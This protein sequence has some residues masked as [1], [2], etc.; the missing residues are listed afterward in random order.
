MIRSRLYSNTKPSEG[1][2]RIRRNQNLFPCLILVCIFDPHSLPSNRAIANTLPLIHRSSLYGDTAKKAD[3]DD[4]RTFNPTSQY[5]HWIQTTARP[6]PR[7]LSMIGETFSHYKIVEKLGEGGMGVVYKAEDLRLGRVVALKFLSHQLGDD[8]TA[9]R[10]LLQ[11][12]KAASAINHQNVCI[13]YDIGE[14]QGKEFISMEYVEGE[15]LRRKF[16]ATPLSMNEA[17][18]YAVQI[19]EGLAAAHDKGII[20]RDVKPDNIMVGPHGVIK[21]MDFGLAKLRDAYLRTRATGTVGTLAYMAPEQIQGG[22]VDARA[23]IFGFGVVLYEMLTQRL[24]FRGAHEAAMMYSIL[25]EEPE[26]LQKHLP[27]A[28]PELIHLLQK[29]LEKEVADR[30]QSIHEMVVDIRRLQKRS[31]SSI[32]TPSGRSTAHDSG[33][34]RLAAIMFTDM[35]GYSA[36]T[37]KNE[38]LALEL[39]STHRRIVRSVLPIYGGKE[40][41][42]IGDGF[43]IE[44]TS[45]LEA[46]RCACT[47]QKSMKEYNDTVGK[48]QQIYLRIGIHIGDVISV[49]NNVQGDGV[50]IAARI[51]PLAEPGG[52]CISEDVARQVKNK[53][54]MPLLKLGKAEL[55][56]IQLPL[57]IYMIVLPWEKQRVPGSERLRFSLRR[58]GVRRAIARAG[59]L[60]ALAVLFTLYR[61]WER[62]SQP[63]AK[64]SVIADSIKADSSIRKEIITQIK[65]DAGGKSGS[66]NLIK[67]TIEERARTTQESKAD[68]PAAATHQAAETIAPP[69]QSSVTVAGYRVAVLPFSNISSDPKDEY[70][71]DGMTEELISTLSR[72]QGLRV[73]ARTSVMQYKGVQKSVVVIGRELNVRAV[74]EGS[75]RKSGNKLR[76]SVQLIDAANQEHLWS[77]EYDRELT[78]VFVIQGNVAQRVAEALQIQLAAGE[79]TQI[80]KSWTGNVEAYTLYLRGRYAWNKR[81]PPDLLESVEYF[82]KAAQK[83]PRYALAFA[84][85]ADAYTLLGNYYV[86]PPTDAYTQAQTAALKALEID[87]SLA[88]AHTSLAFALMHYHWDWAGAEKEFKRAIELNPSYAVGESWY[89]YFLTVTGRFNEAVDVRAK[90]QELDPLSIVISSDVGLTLYF[91]RKYDETVEQ[92]RKT[93]SSDPSFYAAYI[94]LG[95][96]LL[97]LH[98]PDEAVAAFKKARTF[99]QNHPIPSAALAYALAVSGKKEE[100]IK[101]AEGLKKLSSRSY[102]SPYWIGIIYAGLGDDNAAFDWLERGIA[103]HDGS[104]IF[105]KVEPILDRL[106]PDP[107]FARLLANVGLN[108]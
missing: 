63:P 55:K 77:E 22:E 72:I 92:F 96:A 99:S 78:D 74:L 4:C 91:A 20:H 68:V 69:L 106:R 90:A 104:M 23:D 44:F 26:S 85:L 76:I 86:L 16:S 40:V 79:R 42:T 81:S 105:L 24:P 34:R 2:C 11:E 41:G 101:I 88:E 84:G 13:V 35:V 59:A 107:R 5:S 50:N 66:S 9:K 98:R 54:E 36:A 71:A 43:F 32:V 75:V 83:D 12:A 64:P 39:L 102:V 56:N 25:H 14:S 61:L 82:K 80:G 33:Q 46:S 28:P 108:N 49:E 15:T 1:C 100:A 17:V 52:V 8:E 95:A 87:E 18:S 62:P 45:A 60:I 65:P 27:D 73:I 57:D 51:E 7:G 3:A 29:A 19:G 103:S 93:L 58:K 30:Y 67:S 94:P 37:Q 89:A 21:V 48:E 47:I 70:F 97:H 53:L 31:S 6:T 38:A 10:R